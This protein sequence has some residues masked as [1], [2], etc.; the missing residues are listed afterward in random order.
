VDSRRTTHKSDR[1]EGPNF[2]SFELETGTVGTI[3]GF[4]DDLPK[5]I[6]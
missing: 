5:T 2:V 3:K 4:Y 1:S 6:S